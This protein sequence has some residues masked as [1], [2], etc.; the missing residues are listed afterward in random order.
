MAPFVSFI[1]SYAFY[2]LGTRTGDNCGSITIGEND[3]DLNF[4][5]DAEEELF[6]T[7]RRL[8]NAT[9]EALNAAISTCR[10]GSCLTKVGAAISSVTDAYGY[11]SVEKYRGHGVGR[12]FHCPP[13]VKHY[14]NDDYLIL[15]EG[16]VFTIE[17]MLTEA[18][19]DCVE[20]ES[21]GWTVVTRDGGRSAQFE[22]MVA[23][24][25]DGAEV[26]TLPTPKE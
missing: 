19:Q 6:I 1:V 25:E 16:M 17:P 14:R 11:S 10:D 18:R 12:D 21:D 13:F 22:H 20:W 24:T 23:I 7:S 15:K 3:P 2:Y 8:I 9:Q 5:S 26:L 4:T